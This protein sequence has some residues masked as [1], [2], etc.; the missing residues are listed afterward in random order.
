MNM[1]K[2]LKF[3]K[4]KIIIVVIITLFGLALLVGIFSIGMAVGYRKARFSYAWGENYHRNFGGPREGFLGNIRDFGGGDF[5][6]GHGAFG[7]IVKVDNQMIILKGR[8]NIERIILVKDDTSLERFR[9]SISLD[10][11]KAD[12]YIIVLGSPNDLGQIEAKFIR[13]MPAP[14]AS[15]SGRLV[16]G[17]GPSP[18]R[19]NLPR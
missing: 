9:D 1:D 14:L 5:I 8:D 19:S 6:E 13:V 18:I 16:D 17:P 12:D 4:S 2:I 11:L 15:P 3:L 10:D 7:Q